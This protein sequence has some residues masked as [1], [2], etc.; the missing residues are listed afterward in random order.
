MAFS[1]FNIIGFIPSTNLDA[2]NKFYSEL[3]GLKQINNDEYA[4]EYEIKQA[5]LRVAK[6]NKA[7][8]A[9][10]TIFGWEVTDINTVVED[11]KVKGVSFVF[12]DGMP[13][14]DNGI[15]TFPNGEKVAWFKDPDENVLSITQL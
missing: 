6:V 3:L 5:K 10:H 1:S 9:S 12:Y 7:L 11:L 14:N 15:A 13:Q 4:I 8:K 2:S